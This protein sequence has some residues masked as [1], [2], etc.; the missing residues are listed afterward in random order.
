MSEQKDHQEGRSENAPV[1]R[2]PTTIQEPDVTA[3]TGS[4]AEISGAHKQLVQMSFAKVEPIAEAA[5]GLFYD[6]LF[7]L[8]PGLGGAVQD[9][10]H[11][12]GPQADG[13]P[14]LTLIGRRQ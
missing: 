8:D 2:Y 4:S 5:A 10:H 9:R 7:E 3:M 1:A 14:H 11:G 6:K 13:D 12:T